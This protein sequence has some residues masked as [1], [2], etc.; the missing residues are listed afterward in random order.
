MFLDRLAGLGADQGFILDGFPRTLVQAEALDDAL[1][2]RGRAIDLAVNIG[3]PDEVLIERMRGRALESSRSDD[4]PE[5]MRTRLEKQKPPADLLDHYRR[6]GKLRDVDGT[7]AVDAVTE[8][9]TAAL[10]ADAVAR[11]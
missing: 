11:K 2:K 9:I 1:A 6:A 10:A 8:A 5:A 3:A 4:T 7:P